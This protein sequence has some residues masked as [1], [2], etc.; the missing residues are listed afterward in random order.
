MIERNTSIIPS[1]RIFFNDEQRA[2]FLEAIVPYV[3]AAREAYQP[4]QEIN[5][6]LRI[7]DT[8]QRTIEAEVR[9][10]ATEVEDHPLSAA[11]IA[12]NLTKEE[13]Q[14]SAASP[15]P[16][17]EFRL[18]ANELIVEINRLKSKAALDASV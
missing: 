3:L 2:E 8:E 1:K 6:Q 11:L 5:D 13:L 12:I 14:R 16:K 15:E 18:R 10:H 7:L 17:E 9:A 4:I